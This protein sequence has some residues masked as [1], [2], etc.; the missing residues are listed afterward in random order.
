M[1][2][3]DSHSDIELVEVEESRYFDLA[4]HDKEVIPKGVRKSEN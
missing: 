3:I 4:Q 1:N 2:M